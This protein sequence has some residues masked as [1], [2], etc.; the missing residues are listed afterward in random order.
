MR[1]QWGIAP[2][3][4]GIRTITLPVPFANTSYTVTANPDSATGEPPLLSR[5]ILIGGKTTSSFKARA[6]KGDN[7]DSDFSFQWQAIGLKPA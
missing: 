4:S 1:I 3:A 7:A 2:T 6:V 5:A